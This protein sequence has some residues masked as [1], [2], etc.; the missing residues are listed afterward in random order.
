MITQ[1]VR[2]IVNISVEKLLCRIKEEHN[3][4]LKTIQKSYLAIIFSYYTLGMS[5]RSKLLTRFSKIAGFSR[6]S[7]DRYYIHVFFFFLLKMKEF[8]PCIADHIKSCPMLG[9]NLR[10]LTSSGFGVWI[11]VYHSAICA[12]NHLLTK[13]VMVEIYKA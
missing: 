2:S 3:A 10:Y 5:I 11:Y 1:Y 9:S 6:F 4:A 8:N 7:F 12:V 13:K